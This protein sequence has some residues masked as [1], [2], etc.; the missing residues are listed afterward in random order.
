MGKSFK[1]KA[2]C[3]TLRPYLG[4]TE[5]DIHLFS[6]K[7]LKMKY[8][9]GYYFITEK[10]DEQRHIHC[11]IFYDTAK[12]KDSL[13]RALHRIY[14]D[15]WQYRDSRTDWKIA[16]VNGVKPAY[17][18]DWFTNYLNKDPD[19][20]FIEALEISKPERNARYQ[21]KPAFVTKK[22]KP[23][24][25]YF[26]KLQELWNDKNNFPFDKHREITFNNMMYFLHHLMYNKKCLRVIT[27]LTRLRQLAHGLVNYIGYR[28]YTVLWDEKHPYSGQPHSMYCIEKDVCRECESYEKGAPEPPLKKRLRRG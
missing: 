2:W 19:K 22:R 20:V 10:Q 24:D 7:V 25:P 8:I 18:D 14:Y 26:H 23:A 1:T 17:N 12:T 9:R 16:C 28:T 11:I 6:N 13:V 4:I 21:D 15:I 5:E 3:V 27:N